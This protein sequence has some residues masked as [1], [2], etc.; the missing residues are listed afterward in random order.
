M[1]TTSVVT[2]ADIK[3]DDWHTACRL[4]P[5]SYD[6]Q[7]PLMSKAQPMSSDVINFAYVPQ[8]RA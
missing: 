2:P 8:K 7:P 4:V 6:V 1:F 5:T 3:A